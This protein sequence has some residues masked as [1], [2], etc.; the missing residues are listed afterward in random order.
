MAIDAAQ[1]TFMGLSTELR[2][3]IFHH[4]LH[5]PAV[6]QS[7]VC[8]IDHDHS[9]ETHG[10]VA[11]EDLRNRMR[12]LAHVLDLNKPLRSEVQAMR[13][14][15]W[16][17]DFCV[18]AIYDPEYYFY[19]EGR[20]LGPF[21]GV[22]QFDADWSFVPCFVITQTATTDQATM[23]ESL[24]RYVPQIRLFVNVGL[25]EPRTGDDTHAE[26]SYRWFAIDNIRCF[27]NVLHKCK[28]VTKLDVR[29][30]LVYQDDDAALHNQYLGGFK[31]LRDN[32]TLKIDTEYYPTRSPKLDEAPDQSQ[33]IADTLDRLQSS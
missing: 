20:V 25:H 3:M 33:M 32:I 2:I 23:L 17:M 29:L 6:E 22:E 31:H 24:L 8:C 27:I 9:E 4:V 13:F 19:S 12:N 14:P 21:E 10:K 26:D 30:R 15:S 1:A 11:L 7:M 28:R 16:Q 18:S 5:E